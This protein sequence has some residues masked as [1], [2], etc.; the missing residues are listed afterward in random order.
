MR[1][2][3]TAPVI[4]MSV[5]AAPPSAPE[6][7]VTRP[8]F[9]QWPSRDEVAR[10]LLAQGLPAE[11]RA[12]GVSLVCTVGA[13]GNLEN[14]DAHSLFAHSEG[15]KKAA[16]E[17]A[18]SYKTVT[19][20]S[21]GE[22]AVGAKLSFTISFEQNPPGSQGLRQALDPAATADL[23]CAL[24][25]LRQWA[26]DAET[27][28]EMES[29]LSASPAHQSEW[30]ANRDLRQARRQGWD[31][32]VMTF[33]EGR[34]SV[35]NSEIRWRSLFRGLPDADND[36]TFA[37]CEKRMG[38]LQH[39]PHPPPPMPIPSSSPSRGPGS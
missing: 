21:F 33:Y 14:C 26:K 27:I 28:D 7:S 22:D 38:E 12:D 2:L 8:Y 36:A 37:S 17:L 1:A 23:A 25:A 32:E 19:R 3:L 35:R 15:L 31:N 10:A 29:S 13:N 9:V 5:A 24:S 34:L 16:L 18:K 4:L 11:S 20:D 39:M 30:G 6:R